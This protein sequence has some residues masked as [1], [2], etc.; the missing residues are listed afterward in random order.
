MQ[1]LV[2]LLSAL[3]SMCWS[4]PALAN[5]G[6]TPREFLT[7]VEGLQAR[8]RAGEF[9][10]VSLEDGS[11]CSPVI[12]KSSPIKLYWH[13]DPD[14]NNIDVLYISTGRGP[15]GFTLTTPVS[16]ITGI[17]FGLVGGGEQS[18]SCGVIQG[19]T[20]YSDNTNNDGDEPFVD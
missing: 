1:K 8:V 7:F 11:R 9:E 4:L 10:Y 2:P 13:A 18:L 6:S 16:E 15:C 5:C 19:T 14:G 20:R 12:Y 3:M 17:S